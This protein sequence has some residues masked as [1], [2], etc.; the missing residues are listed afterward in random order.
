MTLLI[1]NLFC[2]LS[3]AFFLIFTEN[4]NFRGRKR[5]RRE[6]HQSVAFSMNLNVGSNHSLRTCP[7][8]ESNLQIFHVWVNVPTHWAI[9]QVLGHKSCGP[10]AKD[11]S[12]RNHQESPSPNFLPLLDFH[13]KTQRYDI[14]RKIQVILFICRFC[15]CEFVHSLK[16]ICNS[17]MNIHGTFWVILVLAPSRKSLSPA[18]WTFQAEFE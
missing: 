13:L 4:T 1:I 18:S 11:S 5:G 2:L 9:S 15:I 17:K 3:L 16:F 12:L 6:E 10:V 14:P 8:W 7:D